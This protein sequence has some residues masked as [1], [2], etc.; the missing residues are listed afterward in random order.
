MNYLQTTPPWSG[1]YLA[2][3]MLLVQLTLTV[4]LGQGIF[5]TTFC[6]KRFW[7]KMLLSLMMHS[8]LERPEASRGSSL[9]MGTILKGRFMFSVMR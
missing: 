3:P 1:S 7:S 6:P 5:I 4:L 9:K 2:L 8:I